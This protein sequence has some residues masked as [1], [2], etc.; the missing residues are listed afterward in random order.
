MLALKP[1]HIFLVLLGLTFPKGPQ[2]QEPIKHPSLAGHTGE[3]ET[4]CLPKG[5]TPTKPW[6]GVEDAPKERPLPDVPTPEAGVF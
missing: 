2:S 4:R 3:E 5:L 6:V 1:G